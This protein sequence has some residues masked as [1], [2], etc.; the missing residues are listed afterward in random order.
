MQTQTLDMT[1]LSGP[2]VNL[3]TTLQDQN[4]K[5]RDVVDRASNI[6][7]K[8]GKLWIQGKPEEL[9]GGIKLPPFRGYTPT[10]ICHGQ[11]AD[12]LGI[13]QKYYDR[14]M[15]D[16][17]ELLEYNINMWLAKD[18]QVKYLL[19]TFDG[20]ANQDVNIA[21]A[22]LSDRFHL[23]DNYDV[24]FHALKAIK[25]MGVAVQ[26]TKAEVTER[27][28]YLHIVCPD[29][30]LQAESFLKDYMKSNNAVGNGIVSGLV[31]TNSEVGLGSFEIRP[32]A[33]IVKCNN[34]L[35]VKDESYKRVHLGS[36]MDSGDIVWSEKTKQKNFELVMSQTQDAVQ[37]FLSQ[38]YLG[39]MVSRI[40]DAHKVSLDYPFDAVQNV[41]KE[42]TINDDDKRDI[43]K[44]FV[45]D[46]D[47]HASGIFQAI[48]RKAGSMQT[49][50]QFDLEAAA[51]GIL[52]KI[53]KYDKPFSKN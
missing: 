5:K 38:D 27:R 16:Y 40:A 20:G 29:V 53:K 30:E 34:G 6:T 50:I 43:L 17:P 2:I 46:G 51:F 44:Y 14:M 48:T 23:L 26:I 36:R 15:K 8:D 10:E 37:T 33:V 3:V 9:P 39:K 41:C 24:M 4:T 32:R 35:M 12:K 25:D 49:D 45:E 1:G 18:Q 31:I 22:L 19:R 42:L 21:R 28:M 11:I 13:P 7:Y 52:P 47:P